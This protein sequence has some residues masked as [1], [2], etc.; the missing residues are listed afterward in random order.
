LPKML[1]VHVGPR[2]TGTTATQHALVDDGNSVVVYP[3]VGLWR[4]RSHH[5]LVYKFFGE[6]KL[7]EP[8]SDSLETL[9]AK[10]RDQT[11]QTEKNI[12]ISS[13]VLEFRD[14]DV[15]IRGLLPYVNVEPA[16]VEILLTCREH[17]ARTASLYNHRL[18]AKKVAERRRP[19]R[20]LQEEA[21]AMCY[22]PLIRKLM[23]TEFKVTVLNYHPSET[24]LSRYCAHVGFTEHEFPENKKRMV[25]YS[26][27]ALIVILAINE[28]VESRNDRHEYMK[29]F[30]KM[31]DSRGPSKF[32]FGSQAS[33]VAEGHFS[34]DR[35]FLSRKFGI[36]L[37]P[38]DYNALENDLFIDASD[39]EDI[40]KI[41]RPLGEKGGEITAHVRRYLR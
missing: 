9:L 8:I 6:E 29:F 7:A 41:A 5:G 21:A 37:E 30:A 19:D 27:K 3:N 11:A 13:E 28:V 35:K 26:P 16:N 34:A 1:Y 33:A 2:K 40:E 39:F 14:V 24:W 20:F 10:L 22:E 23:T 36:E 31:P 17:F 32:I 18:G 25:S 12:V 38:P 4:D 15:F